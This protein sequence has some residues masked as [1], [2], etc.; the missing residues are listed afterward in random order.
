MGVVYICIV[1]LCVIG[2][3][4]SGILCEFVLVSLMQRLAQAVPVGMR[5]VLIMNNARIHKNDIML[6]LLSL[7]R[8]DVVF[9]PPYSPFLNIIEMFFNALKMIVKYDAYAARL[10]TL[11]ALIY[12]LLHMQ[13]KYNVV[14][15]HGAMCECGYTRYL[16]W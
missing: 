4:T 14:S 3:V 6:R 16:Q 2:S 8:I 12:A 7:L 1:L 15:V 11:R 13:Q 10:D 9:L 5:L